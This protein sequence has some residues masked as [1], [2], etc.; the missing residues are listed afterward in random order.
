MLHLS[1][2]WANLARESIL[3]FETV[4]QE[5]GKL[6]AKKY[7]LLTECPCGTVMLGTI[8]L[9]KLC[10]ISYVLLCNVMCDIDA[11]SVCKPL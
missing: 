11:T 9:K 2:E 5:S 10:F 8:Q 7:Q 1:P 3:Q 4:K 6:F